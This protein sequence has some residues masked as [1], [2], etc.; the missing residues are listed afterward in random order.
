MARAWAAKRQLLILFLIIMVFGIFVFLSAWPRISKE[1]TCSD[2]IKNGGEQGV[3][4]GGSCRL[5]CE[6]LV[7]PAKVYWTRFF[8]V[9]PGVYSVAAL[10]E[11]PNLDLYGYSR[12]Y[13]FRLYDKDNLFITRVQ[14][15]THLPP[16]SEIAIFEGGIATGNSIP[17][18][19]TF[20]WLDSASWIKIV[21]PGSL[22]SIT[23]IDNERVYDLTTRPRVE[24]TVTNQ[25]AETLPR[26]K[27]VAVLFDENGNALAASS[28]Y[29]DPI[30]G[31][32][33]RKIYFSWQ[34]PIDVVSPR[35]EIYTLYDESLYY[36]S[37]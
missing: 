8:E 26:T 9:A 35:I 4:C 34:N 15:Y 3:D 21:D 29:S 18:S 7:P 19:A 36:Y 28:T 5:M 23:R 16:N 25:K 11:N 17:K 32:G 12:P 30:E 27:F 33:S 20:D 1:P 10:V 2:G 6:E 14:G 22:V 37:Q 24:A 13:E 31:F